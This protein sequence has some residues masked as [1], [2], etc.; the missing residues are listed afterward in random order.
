[1]AEYV[2]TLPTDELWQADFFGA[3]LPLIT[4]ENWEAHGT[5]TPEE[6]ADYWSGVLLSQIQNRTGMSL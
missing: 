1:M 2:I 6:M 4:E 3:I 5:L